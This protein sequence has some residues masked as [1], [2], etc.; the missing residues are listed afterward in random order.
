MVADYLSSK[1][2][3]DVKL[4]LSIRVFGAIALLLAAVSTYMRSK[5]AQKAR[6]ATKNKPETQPLECGTK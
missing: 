6:L 5:K 3:A 2:S 4:V 1:P